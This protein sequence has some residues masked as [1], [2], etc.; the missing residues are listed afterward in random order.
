MIFD[1]GELTSPKLVQ[2][3]LNRIAAYDTP[4]GLNLNAIISLNPNVLVQAAALDAERKA[5]G[6]RSLLCRFGSGHGGQSG[7]DRHWDGSVP[8]STPP[9]VGEPVPGP[10][11]LAGTAMAWRSSRQLRRRLRA[12]EV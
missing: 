3:Y 9:L 11:A 5:T 4:S 8:A 10:L 2:L 12:A 1:S 6:P 7:H